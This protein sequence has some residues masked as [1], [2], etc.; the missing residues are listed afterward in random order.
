MATLSLS[1][2]SA[3]NV[4]CVNLLPMTDAVSWR[5]AHRSIGIGHWALGIGI[6]IG[7]D[8]GIGICSHLVEVSVAKRAQPLQLKAKHEKCTSC[9]ES[10]TCFQQQPPTVGRVIQS[11][12]D[13]ITH[14]FAAECLQCF[15]F[16]EASSHSK[17]QLRNSISMSVPMPMT[18]PKSRPKPRY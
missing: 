16:S 13:Y 14:V 3:S 11:R 12:G 15:A 2:I 7:I 4:D 17:V 18:M 9:R 8:I 5:Y 1:W 6:G 10:I